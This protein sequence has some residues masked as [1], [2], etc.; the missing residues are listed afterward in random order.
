MRQ[1]DARL[2]SS[3]ILRSSSSVHL[4]HDNSKIFFKRFKRKNLLDIALFLDSLAMLSNS[5]Q[6]IC[7]ALQKTFNCLFDRAFKVC[8][9]CSWH[10]MT[11]TSWIR[12]TGSYSHLPTRCPLLSCLRLSLPWE[13]A[14]PSCAFHPQLVLVH[15]EHIGHEKMTQAGDQR[16]SW[17]PSI[18]NRERVEDHR[19]ESLEQLVFINEPII[20][21]PWKDQSQHFNLGGTRG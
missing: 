9:S 6:L 20:D 3:L 17:K 4:P 8:G 5:D 16:Q 11:A 21:K 19:W 15:Y 14:R 2:N 10:Q 7:K 13:G 1:L 18:H 12:A